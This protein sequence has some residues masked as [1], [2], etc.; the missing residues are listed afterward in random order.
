M[1]RYATFSTGFEYKFSFGSQSSYDMYRFGGH[2]FHDITP[3]SEK[4][5][6]KSLKI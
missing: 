6:T 3:F 4:N 2:Q 1:G 5:E